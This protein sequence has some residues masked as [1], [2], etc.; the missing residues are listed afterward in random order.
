MDPGTDD[1]TAGLL[2]VS[3]TAAFAVGWYLSA[4]DT[5]DVLVG[6]AD[7]DAGLMNV[8]FEHINLDLL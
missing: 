2:A 7:M 5:I 4:A 1:D 6:G 8:F 3:D